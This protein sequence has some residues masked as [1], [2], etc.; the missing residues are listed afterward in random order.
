MSVVVARVYKNR[1]EMAADSICVRGWSKVNGDSKKRV[2]MI[3]Y[4]DM[5]LGGCGY[6]EETSLFFMYMKT[7]VIENVDEQGVLDFVLEFKRWKK[8][9][10]GN[11]DF[12]NSYI[13]AL[14]GKCFGIHGAY[15]YEIDEYAAIG[16]GED[17]ARG[18][19]YMGATPSEAVKAACDLCVYVSEPI[20]SETIPVLDQNG[21]EK[22]KSKE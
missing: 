4:H 7:H 17:Y 22:S 12:E 5:I 8:D 9:Y 21:V 16:A 3:K 20:I 14:Q 11:D 15:I 10:V 18:A 2:K 1:I 13:V 19:L 6:A